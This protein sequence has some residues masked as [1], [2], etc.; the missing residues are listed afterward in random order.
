[1]LNEWA[2]CNAKKVDMEC[3]IGSCALERQS[4]QGHIASI[5]LNGQVHSLPVSATCDRKGHINSAGTG[6]LNFTI[7]EDYVETE[8]ALGLGR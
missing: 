1:M 2:P 4:D 5:D 7:I 3:P 6:A 8:F